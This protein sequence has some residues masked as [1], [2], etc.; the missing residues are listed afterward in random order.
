MLIY[1]PNQHQNNFPLV[2]GQECRCGAKECRG[3]IG[4]KNKDFLITLDGDES[5]PA[6]NKTQ[7]KAP[8][9]QKSSPT[10]RTLEDEKWF[11]SKMSKEDMQWIEKNAPKP[12]QLEAKSIKCTVCNEYLDFKA[13][14][15]CHRHPDLGLSVLVINIFFTCPFRCPDVQQV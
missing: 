14:S 11:A 12:P 8:T 4:G 6:N 3:I 13:Q 9:N 10:S 7:L 15:T 5:E 2:K 1:Q